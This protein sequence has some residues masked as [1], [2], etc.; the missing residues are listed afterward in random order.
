M[1]RHPYMDEMDRRV[2]Q[3]IAEGDELRRQAATEKKV[4][5]TVAKEPESV[6]P[7]APP[8]PRGSP[9]EKGLACPICGLV[10]E[11]VRT[12]GETMARHLP[13]VQGLK[14]YRD[15]EFCDGQGRPGVN[16]N[17]ES[18]KKAAVT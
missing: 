4:A 16:P 14:L 2:R 18:P 5:D 9:N 3:A 7:K 15:T 8:A 6:E 10:P 1:Y 13:A 11:R 12:D 17:V